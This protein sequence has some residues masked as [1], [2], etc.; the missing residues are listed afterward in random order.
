LG[1]GPAIRFLGTLINSVTWMS[2]EEMAAVELVIVNMRLGVA[3]TRE[4]LVPLQLAIRSIDP[5][6]S[7]GADS[8]NR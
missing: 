2:L 1:L 3:T 8:V 7:A 4:D 5:A 6:G